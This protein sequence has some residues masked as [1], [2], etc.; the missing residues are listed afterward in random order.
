MVSDFVKG[1]KKFDY[2]I[3]IQ[4]GIMLHRVI[5]TFTDMHEA[6]R[7]AKEIFRP[8]YRLYSG[9]FV[10]VL[11]DHFLANDSTEFSEESL[12]AFSQQVYA[13][14]DKNTAWMPEYFARM[15]PFMKQHNWLLNYRTRWG[16]QKSL[17]G[18]VRRSAY[19]TES[20]IAFQLFEQHYQLL[21]G[22]YRHFWAAVKPFARQQF[23][24]LQNDT[25]KNI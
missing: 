3:D 8:V 16:I 13:H 2:P 10:D 4:K 5:D 17:G 19:L 20:D 6:T 23:E 25:G 24:L 15:F 22:C 1:R 12:S 9:A 18:V 14:L 7:E 11:Y 21:E